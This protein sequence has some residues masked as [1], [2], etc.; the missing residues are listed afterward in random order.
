MSVL[1]L[2]RRARAYRDISRHPIS[3]TV[4]TTRAVLTVLTSVPFMSCRCMS[5]RFQVRRARAFS[6]VHFLNPGFDALMSFVYVPR[7]PQK[8]QDQHPIRNVRNTRSCPLCASH[9]RQ[10]LPEHPR[11]PRGKFILRCGREI[12][13]N[14]SLS[15]M[16]VVCVTASQPP[17][18]PSTCTLTTRMLSRTTHIRRCSLERSRTFFFARLSL[19]LVL[20]HSDLDLKARR[21]GESYQSLHAYARAPRISL[22]RSEPESSICATISS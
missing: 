19:Y 12:A 1:L 20:C 13:Y 2:I 21:P 8:P 7:S 22:Y 18:S 5:Y 14:I 10:R 11:Y 9:R 15:E 4:L 17:R 6:L 16:S 3:G